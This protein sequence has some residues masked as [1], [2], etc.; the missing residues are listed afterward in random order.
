MLLIA[1][2]TVTVRTVAV[3][4]DGHGWDVPSYTDG[5]TGQG[6]LI[7]RSTVRQSQSDSTVYEPVERATADLQ[8]PF[9]VSVK[10]GDIVVVNGRDWLVTGVAEEP[11]L[12]DVLNY[13]W[14]Q[15]EAGEWWRP[16]A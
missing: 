13:T 6:N 1:P 12:G 9:S 16:H 3:V 4:D 5:W 7:P 15:V 11:G 8:L 14:C 2:D 10:E